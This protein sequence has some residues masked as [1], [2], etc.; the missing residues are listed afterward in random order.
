MQLPVA[1]IYPA[2]TQHG[3]SR[4]P[5][6]CCPKSAFASGSY[7]RSRYSSASRCESS[8]DE[9]SASY[10][11]SSAD[12]G[13]CSNAHASASNEIGAPG[14]AVCIPAT[15]FPLS[16]LHHT[17]CG[18][19]ACADGTSSS[20]DGTSKHDAASRP[21]STASHESADD[22]VCPADGPTT[23]GGSCTTSSH[24]ASERRDT[25]KEQRRLRGRLMVEWT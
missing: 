21:Q 8:R 3:T 17:P 2:R 11:E 20:A 15:G 22:A 10:G 9:S 1:E 25:H 16:R 12:D 5:A 13:R 4:Q 23:D 14:Y 18:T 6:A 19:S 24:N 7:A